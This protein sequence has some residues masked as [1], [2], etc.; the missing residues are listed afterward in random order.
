MGELIGRSWEASEQ[1]AKRESAALFLTLRE[2]RREQREKREKREKAREKEKAERKKLFA[3]FSTYFSIPH[4]LR[5]PHPRSPGRDVPGALHGSV[6]RVHSRTIVSVV[7]QRREEQL[8][9]VR[10]L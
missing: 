3:A 6:R 7:I 1:Q 10:L 2:K 4:V 5:C 9:R 8:G